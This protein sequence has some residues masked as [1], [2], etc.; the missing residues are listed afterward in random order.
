MKIYRP[1]KSN[2]ITQDFGQSLACVKTD[3]NRNIIFP[4]TVISKKTF[5]PVG[6]S[7][8]YKSMGLEGHNGRDNMAWNGEPLYFPVD[9]TV[10]WW[11]KNEV[12]RDGGIGLD[13]ISV[14]PIK[15]GLIDT[16]VK[17][18]FWHLKESVIK[19]GQRVLFGQHI[20]YCDNTGSSSGSHLHWSFKPCDKNGQP[21][22]RDNGYLGATDFE[23]WYSNEFVLDILGVKTKALS[24]IQEANR[25]ISQIALL[26]RFYK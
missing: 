17:F 10:G 2:R 18:R 15:V 11:A 26:L 24:A 5:C 20:G 6:Y 23:P 9:K 1:V 14:M 22:K 3:I 16:Y 4:T 12:D 7:D 19:D 25:L 21:T 8:F 13:I